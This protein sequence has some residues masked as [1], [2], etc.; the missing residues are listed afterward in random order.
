[1]FKVVHIWSM[2][3][4]W[5]AFCTSVAYLDDVIEDL[6][7]KHTVWM[8][9]DAYMYDGRFTRGRKFQ[10]IGGQISYVE[11][12]EIVGDSP[13]NMGSVV[14][15]PDRNPHEFGRAY[16]ITWRSNKVRLHFDS[17]SIKQSHTST[18]VNVRFE[19]DN[20]PNDDD[21]QLVTGCDKLPV[22][23]NPTQST[24]KLVSME[25]EVPAIR[26]HVP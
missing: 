3:I 19:N 24:L 8:S 20:L 10:V 17:L 18:W 22:Q 16:V 23:H 4:Y 14:I 13:L 6:K 7:F 11:S 15:S 9:L 5:T 26:P 21:V 25:L 12:L 2:L 1:M